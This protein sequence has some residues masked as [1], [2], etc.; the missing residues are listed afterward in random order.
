[1]HTIHKKSKEDLNSHLYVDMFLWKGAFDKLVEIYVKYNECSKNK[2]L[3]IY[4]LKR[5][6]W[7]ST[8]NLMS[9]D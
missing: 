4:I 3:T 9:L 7:M 2:I 6:L 8:S 1:M 5:T